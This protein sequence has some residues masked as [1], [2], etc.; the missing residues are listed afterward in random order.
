VIFLSGASI[1]FISYG[2]YHFFNPSR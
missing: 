2:I 1:V